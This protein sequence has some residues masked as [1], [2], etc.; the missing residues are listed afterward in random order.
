MVM[1]EL[2]QGP[3]GEHF[4]IEITQRKILDVGYWWLTMYRNVHDYFGSCDA[5]P[6]IGGLATQRFAKL[7]ISLLKDPFMKWGFDFVGPIKPTGRYTWNKYILVATNYVTKWVETKA[8]KN[9]IKIVIAKQLYEC[10]LTKF[11]CLLIIVTD[12][13]VHFI[14]DAIK[15]LTNHFPLKHV[16]S[17]AY[18]PQGNG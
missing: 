11:G 13:E 5:C 1:K 12:Q 8:L 16:S 3:L 4:A 18:Y 10:I 7:V 17:I 15:Y 9:D 14:N 6:R 2:H